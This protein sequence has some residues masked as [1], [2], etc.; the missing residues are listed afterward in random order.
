MSINNIINLK[1]NRLEKDI[2]DKL[3]KFPVANLDDAMGRTSAINQYIR[4]FNKSKLIGTA[5]TV[6]VAQG[7]N[8]F[9]HKAMD[10]AKSG[11]VII[12]DSLG[13]KNRAIFGELMA[14]Y[15]KVRGINGII[16]DG[17]IRDSEELSSWNDMAIYASGVSPNGPYKNGPGEIGTTISLGGQVIRPGDIIVGDAD[18][19]VVIKSE[20]ANEV[21]TK[22]KEINDKEEKIISTMKT[23]GTY[24]REWVNET[25]K[26]IGTK[27][28]V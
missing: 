15:C 21:L 4:P 14:S 24:K 2:L 22:V 26:K 1:F 3:K 19:V 7:D 27:I 6:K 9:L 10:L 17:C 8:L 23:D 13:T 28:I 11:D 18:G 5:F 12:I 16:T 20:E 25:L